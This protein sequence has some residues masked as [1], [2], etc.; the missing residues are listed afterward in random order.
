[1]RPFSSMSLWERIRRIAY[2]VDARFQ[3]SLFEG[4]RSF[5]EGW[6]GFSRTME[7]FKVTG[8]RKGAVFALSEGVT[9]GAAGLMLLLA[10]AIPAFDEIEGDDW[11]KK[12]ALSVTFTDRYGDEIGRRGIRH[13]DSATLDDFPEH[14]V[15]AALATEDRRFYDHFGIDAVGTLRA[16]VTNAQADGVVQGGSTI[17]QQL[18]KNLF[19]S[20]ERSLERKIKEAF[21]A[22]W[23]ESRLSK[24]EI[25]K[26]YLDRAYMGGGAF[27]VQAAS[28][29]YFDKDVRNLTLAEAA[30]MAGL[31]KA[32]TKYAPHVNLPAARARANVVLS[33][34]VEAGFLTDG[35]V[36]G[37]RRNPAT[38]VARA[39]DA[40]PD[41]YLDYAFDEM[42]RLAA[43]G[44]FGGETVLFVKTAFDPD[45]QRRTDLVMEQ[46]LRVE[47]PERRFKQGAAVVLDPDGA[48]RAIYGGRDYGQSQFNRAT[49]A[50]RQP[51]STF[52]P[53]V[54]AA[55]LASGRFTPESVVV[56]RPTCVGN[57][58]PANFTRSFSGSM[59]LTRALAQSINTIPVQLA[60]AIG[61]GEN[62]RGRLKVID[63]MARMG[64]ASPMRDVRPLTLGAVEMTVMDQAVGYA[65]FA[66]GGERVTPH[67]ALEVRNGAGAMLYAHATDGPRPE[68]ALPIAVAEAMNRMMAQVVEAGTGTR[69][70]LNGVVAGGKTGST[71]NYKDVWFVGYTG[72]AVAAVWFGNDDSTSM[73]DRT[74]GGRIAAPAWKGIMTFVHE[75]VELKPLPGVE[76]KAPAA[77]A[78]PAEP[79]APELVFDRRAITMSRRSSEA[80][81]AI[82]G[83]AEEEKARRAGVRE[84]SAASA[85][86]GIV[87]ISRPV[88]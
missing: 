75:G 65:V 3:H 46:T 60:T 44:R 31:F 24:R 59:T 85:G 58:C 11:L 25:L 4:N 34:M 5:A 81:G 36:L 19:L 70:R 8:W 42:Q 47:G 61:E 52:K 26:L 67:A 30:M 74:T 21:L 48:L 68:R 56:D 37:A 40:S 49:N 13:D 41:Y 35:Q 77:E 66:N 84:V 82:R 71:S 43:E 1:M 33:N 62:Q 18:A 2:D 23:L 32:P 10:L 54:Y 51:G 76:P 38:P 50:L 63:L 72:N 79:V 87:E 69:G 16:L 88:D 53:Y 27:G 78:E 28:L 86:P 29:F 6:N 45:I 22:L 17:T 64:I 15:K 57:W 83:L 80:I 9:L 7:F 20:N 39:A 14:L 12:Q 55:A 73:A